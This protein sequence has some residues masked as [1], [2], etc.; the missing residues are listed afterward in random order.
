MKWGEVG[1]FGERTGGGK[2]G[3]VFLDVGEHEGELHRGPP[4]LGYYMDFVYICFL[5]NM[6][7]R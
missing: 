7:I 1:N 6:N 2:N 3:A 4:V 5:A